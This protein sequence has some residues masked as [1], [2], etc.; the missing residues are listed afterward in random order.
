LL[1]SPASL[2]FGYQAATTSA[3][4]TF[5]ATFRNLTGP[6]TLTSSD[7][8]FQLSKDGVAFTNTLTYTVAEANFTSAS[9]RV[10]F[11]PTQAARAYAGTITA[12]T[13]GATN[14]V[15][16]LAGNTY[17]PESTLDVVNWNIEWFG[18]PAQA[19]ADDNLQQANA[20]AILT[21]LN[22]DVY[23]LTEIVDTAR[24]GTVVRQLPGGYRYRVAEFASLAPDANSPNFVSAQKLVFVYRTSVVSNPTF[25]GLLRC[26]GNTTTCPQYNAWASGRFPYLM[27]AD[28]TVNGQ[29]QRVNFV[30]IHGKAN[31]NT[32]VADA[33]EAYDRRK[34]GADA[35]KTE[36][37]TRFGTGNVLVLGDFNDD[38]DQTVASGINTT[39]T[40]FSSFTTD[41]ANYVALTLPL[42]QTG[43]R[44]TV[45]FGDVIDH[46]VVSSELNTSYLPGTAQI[47]TDLAAQIPNYANT[48]SDHFPVLTRFSFGYV[49]ATSS[50]NKLNAQLEVYP[51]PATH[52]VQLR[53]PAAAGKAVQ[54]QVSSADG[55]TITQASGSLEQVNQQFNQQL[56]ILSSGVYILRITSASQTYVKRIVKQ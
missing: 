20:L 4:Q 19:P 47:R 54:L 44:S 24:L 13:T 42:S 38:L 29:Q 7:P 1:L 45:D 25:S 18:S 31:E 3:Q 43:Q 21:A 8:T 28:V 12:S 35:L 36:L 17:A 26:P 48:T 49:T 52:S 41:A 23:G 56:S 39:A 46:V 30:L 22:A 14:A 27:E 53:L 32:S 11:A 5:T 51:N 15:V 50:A 9:V 2:A 33:Q 37:D 6:V 16:N 10:R 34:A 55:R 40:S